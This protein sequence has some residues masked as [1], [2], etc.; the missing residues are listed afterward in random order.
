VPTIEYR[1]ICF[2]GRFFNAMPFK[3]R[4]TGVSRLTASVR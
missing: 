4:A 1:K 2:R 3:Y